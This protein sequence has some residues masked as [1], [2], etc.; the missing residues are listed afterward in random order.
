M[1][2]PPFSLPLIFLMCFL[3]GMMPGATLYSILSAPVYEERLHN[4]LIEGNSDLAASVC[5]EWYASGQYSSGL[6]NWN[7]NV[8]MSVE[9]GSL[10]LTQGEHDTYPAL[11]L[12]FALD[13][14]QDI[15]VLNVGLLENEPYRNM[16]IEHNRLDWVSKTGSVQNLISQLLHPKIAVKP[17]YCSVL[18]DKTPFEPEKRNLYITGL[19]L[20]YSLSPFDNLALLRHNVE[21][22]FRT[23]YLR[24][25]FSPESDPGTVS[26]LNLSYIPA[27]LLIHRYYTSTGQVER[28]SAWKDLT[29]KIGRKGGRESETTALF[30]GAQADSNLI[31]GIS[32]KSLE[33]GMM[34]VG[35]KLYASQTEL[36]NGQYNLFLEDLLKNK[37][38]DHLARCGSGKTNWRA[39]VPKE[40][41]R[42][43]DAEIF[44]NGH[45]DDAEAPVENIAFKSAQDYCAWIT[46]VYNSYTGKKKY[47]KVLFRLPTIAEWEDAARG[48]KQKNPYPWGGYYV[49]NNKGCYLCNLKATEPCKDCPTLTEGSQD[50]GFFPV[51]VTSYFPNDFGLY[52]MSGNVAEMVQEQGKTKGGSW[53]DTAF[54][55]QIT[56]TGTYTEPGPTIGFRVFM[57][58]IEE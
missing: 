38:Y 31:S 7:Y 43:S 39:L 26:Q 50:G 1:K 30:D 12:Q 46:R 37:E 48:G 57:E 14:R 5:R 41:Q 6:L 51:K 21:N 16:C 25:E 49:R 33:K 34:K 13:V 23:D 55:C 52:N 24:L 47:K 36:T 28:A 8:L 19:A 22:K 4:A 11:L 56:T 54:Q 10:L 32:P 20:K 17:V 18:L 42:L 44:K 29:L 58:V 40:Y 15:G 2:Q 45:P 9:Q 3:P 27:F 35:G 53:A